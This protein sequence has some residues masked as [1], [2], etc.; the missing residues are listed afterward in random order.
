MKLSIL[1]L[2]M[3]SKNNFIK[4]SAMKKIYLMI[5][6][7][8]AFVSASSAQCIP[9]TSITH[10][11]PG[12]YPDTL[13]GLPHSYVGVPYQADIQVKVFTNT[14]YMGVPATIDSIIVTSVAGLPP[15]FVYSCTPSNCLF[16]GGSDACILLSGSAPS[17]GIVGAYPLTVN[18]T[19]YGKVFGVPQSIPQPITSYTIYIENNVGI[20]A[21]SNLSFLVGQNVPN[22]ASENTL[23]PVNLPHSSLVHYTVS[24]LLGK[25]V[26]ARELILQKGSNTIPLNLQE[27]PAGIY[28][29]T[30][31]YGEQSLTRRMIVSEN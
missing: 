17:A 31:T 15:G 20:S 21:L 6:I 26:I 14:T 11:V 30:I 23:I 22:P 3:K 12:I 24:N 7:C 29:Y 4:N 19:V 10:N 9:D 27:L 16:P 1:S 18:T 28:L 13:I 2:W 5:A 8:I 25:K